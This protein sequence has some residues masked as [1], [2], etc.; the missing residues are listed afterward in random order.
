M[1]SSTEERPVLTLELLFFP[2]IGAITSCWRC[3]EF[4]KPKQKFYMQKKLTLQNK[5]SFQLD[6]A[7]Q[8]GRRV[9]KRSPETQ[10]DRSNVQTVWKY[11]KEKKQAG[12]ARAAL[13]GGVGVFP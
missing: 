4:I 12:P 6:P 2:Q 7:A 8:Q 11:S 13:G 5:Y 10:I 1:A 9:E 3:V